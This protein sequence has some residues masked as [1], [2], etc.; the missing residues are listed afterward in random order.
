MPEYVRNT[1]TRYT[2]TDR[3]TWYYLMASKHLSIPI[4]RVNVVFMIRN[5]SLRLHG[6]G[7]LMLPQQSHKCAVLYPSGAYPVGICCY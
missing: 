1:D 4:C 6:L 3:T 2:T 5:V 7:R